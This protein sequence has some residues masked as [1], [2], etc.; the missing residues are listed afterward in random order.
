MKARILFLVLAVTFGFTSLFGVAPDSIRTAALRSLVASPGIDST[1]MAL[2]V[3]DLS[4]GET[5][6]SYHSDRPLIPASIMKSITVATLLMEREPSFTYSTPVYTT[7]NVRNGV[8]EGNLLVAGSGDP[9]LGSVKGPASADI[10]KEIT[11]A[12]HRQKIDSI[13][14]RIIIDQSVFA[15]PDHPSS[16]GSGDLKHSYG[17]PSHGFNFENNASGK[18]A[19]LNPGAVFTARLERAMVSAGI[20]YGGN[21]VAQGDKRLLLTHKSATL[22]EIMR[23]CMMRSDNLFAESMLRT[24]SV[25]CG[26]DGSTESGARLE[27]DYWKRE[28][29]PMSNV[30]IIDGSGLSRSNRLTPDFVTGVLRTMAEDV[31]YASFFP[32]AGQEGTL[33]RFMA[34]TPL[35]SYLAMKT[36]SMTGVQSYAG[37]LL[38]EDFAPTHTVVVITNNLKNRDRF[39]SDLS[40]F[41]Q[42]IFPK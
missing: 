14:G 19:V 30:Q 9:S 37:Y 5:I 6:A 8:L 33:R 3:T 21:S 24:Y 40:A 29:M 35:D 12:L 31:D 39:R 13:A 26:Q 10:I 11:D 17:T 42:A 16:W 15:G 28:K 4:T 34:G 25:A 38:D 32:L 2:L 36:G 18:S 20:R 23:S 22:E 27:T 1:Q 41:L 7:G